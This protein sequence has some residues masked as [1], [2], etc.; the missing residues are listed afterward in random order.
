MQKAQKREKKTYKKT[1]K[2]TPHTWM[3]TV[4]LNM[5]MK[6]LKKYLHCQHF[7]S[8]YTRYFKYSIKTSI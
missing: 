8:I 1:G 6:C 7:E 4:N 3:Q 2:K 5:D